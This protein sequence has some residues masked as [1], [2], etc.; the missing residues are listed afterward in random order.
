MSEIICTQ[1]CQSILGGYDRLITGCHW[2]ADLSADLQYTNTA[3]TPS[4]HFDTPINNHRHSPSSFVCCYKHVW[5]SILSF[6]FFYIVAYLL[7]YVLYIIIRI[8]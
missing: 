3:H 5:S 1:S 2:T 7:Y 6:I 8:E 4:G